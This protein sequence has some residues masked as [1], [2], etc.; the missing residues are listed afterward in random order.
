M[1]LAD[2]KAK[3]EADAR[4]EAGK[5]IGK[6]REMAMA[7]SRE[8]DGEIRKIEESYS[9]RLEKEEPEILRRRQIVADL[10]VK[11]IELGVRQNAIGAAFRSALDVLKGLPADQYLSFVEKL[12]DRAVESGNEKLCLSSTERHLTREWLAGYNQRRNRS[13][14][15][16]EERKDISGGFILQQG[17]VETN[18]SWEMLLLWI[19]DDIEADVVQRLFSA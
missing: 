8:A 19:R 12:L 15:L 1:S 13:L 3:I 6:A 10:D 17:D 2:I 4:E 5:I 14:S 7:V 16:G 9:A 18:C 11:K